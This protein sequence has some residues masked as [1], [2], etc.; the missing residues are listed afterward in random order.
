MLALALTRE[1]EI[2]GEA[3][4]KVS[5]ECRRACNKIPWAKIVAMRN[6]VIHGYESI[7]LDIVWNT[8]TVE[9][10][11]LVPALENCLSSLDA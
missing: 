7:N 6:R 5:E 4:G 2:I 3:A 1:I 10:P 11:Q 8:V 9:L